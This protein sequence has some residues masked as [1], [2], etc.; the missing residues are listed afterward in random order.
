MKV[1]LIGNMNN[2]HFSLMRYLRDLGMD[3]YLLLYADE[4]KHFLPEHDTWNL[5]K[6]E[7]FIIKTSISNGGRDAFWQLFRPW[8]IAKQV[9]GF[10]RIIANGFF[11]AYAYV[12]RKKIDIFFPYGTGG[13]FLVY[14]KDFGSK[15]RFLVYNFFQAHGLKHNT[16][17]VGTIDHSERNIRQFR[18]LRVPIL[19]FTVPMVYNREGLP[20]LLEMPRELSKLREIKRKYKVLFSHA[21]QSWVGETR[22]KEA[23]KNDIFIEGFAEYLQK[24]DRKGIRLFLVEYGVDVNESKKLISSLGID[25]YVFW[26]PKMSRK[27]IMLAL[28]YVD[29][30]ASEFGGIYFGGVG[31]EFLSKGI[32]FLHYFNCS[33]KDFLSQTGC[34]LPEFIN[35]CSQDEI[36]DKLLRFEED[37]EPFQ[38]KGKRLRS[39][40]DEYNGISLAARIKTILET[41]ESSS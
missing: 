36:A 23:K 38:E 13:E 7:P 2:N 11:P 12:I 24:S 29:I 8:E 33:E 39:W 22:G 16:R 31:W 20:P 9:E 25:S 6:W 41:E 1:A 3:A 40:F 21:R 19:P 32:P 37:E 34:R 4:Q 10:D 28:D 18:A 14:H 27:E 5:A 15:I 17:Y 35:V 30:G 26:L